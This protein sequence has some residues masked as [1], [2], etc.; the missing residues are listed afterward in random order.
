MFGAINTEAEKYA[1]RYAD[2]LRRLINILRTAGKDCVIPEKET[3]LAKLLLTNGVLVPLLNEGTTIYIVFDTDPVKRSHIR[4][5]G[6]GTETGE[7]IYIYL[8]EVTTDS[9]G[10]EKTR[11]FKFRNRDIG[12]TIFLTEEAANEQ[13]AKNTAR[14]EAQLQ[15]EA[16]RS[17]NE[18]N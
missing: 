14:K 10:R 12:D 16:A 9:D 2:Q 3:L 11:Y 4:S 8:F 18:R 7:F 15:K 1:E 6:V 17:L 5:V 13:L